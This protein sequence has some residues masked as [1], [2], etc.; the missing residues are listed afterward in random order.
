MFVNYSFERK[1]KFATM[2]CLLETEK[3]V[4]LWS[5][6]AD[7][8]LHPSLEEL[9]KIFFAVLMLRSADVRY[10]VRK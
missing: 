6:M 1:L 10:F 3:N 2:V 7:K 8:N 5:E 9:C 4:D